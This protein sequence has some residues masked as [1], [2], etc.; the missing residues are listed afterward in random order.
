M[1][2]RRTKVNSVETVDSTFFYVYYDDSDDGEDN[3]HW[4]M[5]DMI[6]TTN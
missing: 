6:A 4:A 1:Y 3:P 5:V 2:L